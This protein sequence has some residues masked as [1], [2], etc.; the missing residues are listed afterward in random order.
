MTF[1]PGD[2]NMDGI[3]NGQDIAL[4]A[5]NWLQYTRVGDAN[6]DGLVNGQDIALIAS[7]WLQ[8][9][10]EGVSAPEPRSWQLALAGLATVGICSYATRSRPSDRLKAGRMVPTDF[11]FAAR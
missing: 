2:V 3:V 5:T 7:H 8:T 11:G 9:G 4:V 6:D 1:P 10:G